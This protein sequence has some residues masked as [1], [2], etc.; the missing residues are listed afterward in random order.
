MKKSLMVCDIIL[1]AI[2]I[3]MILA[4]VL[5]FFY[6]SAV[7]E[8]TGADIEA[9]QNIYELSSLH[10]AVLQLTQVSFLF[11]IFILPSVTLATYLFFR[12][13]VKLGKMDIQSFQFFT[14]LAF[15]ICFFDVINNLA[16]LLGRMV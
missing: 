2:V 16:L 14:N 1:V 11:Q 13:K 15:F 9:I 7:A 4:R 5:T 3:M 8:E 12:R 10:K 6:I